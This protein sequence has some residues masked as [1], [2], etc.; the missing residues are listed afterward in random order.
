MARRIQ[1]PMPM[2]GSVV[3]ARCHHR[4]MTS[5]VEHLVNVDHRTTPDG[6]EGR[7]WCSCGWT[8]AWLWARR[9]AHEAGADHVQSHF[10]I[11]ASLFR[12][13]R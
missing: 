7:S 12:R 9:G 2:I 11:R 6:V 3:G 8:S 1:R 13:A 10:L 4:G 5:T